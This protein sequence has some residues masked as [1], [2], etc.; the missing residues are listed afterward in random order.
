M[1]VVYIMLAI[2]IGLVGYGIFK[3]DSG[4]DND[5]KMENISISLMQELERTN[6]RVDELK[7]E[8]EQLKTT[9]IMMQEKLQ[10]EEKKQETVAQ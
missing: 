8:I 1:I 10:Y 9:E 7:Q 2:G 5:H 4:E 3:K 6:K